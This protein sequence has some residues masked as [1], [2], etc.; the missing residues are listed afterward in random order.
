MAWPPASSA[1][2]KSLY[3]AWKG[4][5]PKIRRGSIPGA[6]RL[7]PIRETLKKAVDDPAS[8]VKDAT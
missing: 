7:E 2:K 5:K 6:L 4:V 1:H 3:P 8:I